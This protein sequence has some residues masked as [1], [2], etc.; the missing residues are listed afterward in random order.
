MIYNNIDEIIEEMNPEALA[1]YLIMNYYDYSVRLSD[2]LNIEVFN[3][4]H[5]NQEKMYLCTEGE[6]N[7]NN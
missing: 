2:A 7:G 1:D 5:V 6:K 4:E 3:A